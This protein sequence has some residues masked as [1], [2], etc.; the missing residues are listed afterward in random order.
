MMTSIRETKGTRPLIGNL[1]EFVAGSSD[2]GTWRG[3]V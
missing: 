1:F 2:I 3:K